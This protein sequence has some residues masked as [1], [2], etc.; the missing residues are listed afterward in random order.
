M[1]IRLCE[2]KNKMDTHS[3]PQTYGRVDSEHTDLQCRRCNKLY[4]RFRLIIIKVITTIG[5]T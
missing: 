2:H 3:S 5:L 1:Y 4:K